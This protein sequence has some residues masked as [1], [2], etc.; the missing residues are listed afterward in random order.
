MSDLAD[1]LLARFVEDQEAAQEAAR[2]PA[3]PDADAVRV[4]WYR[5]D[6]GWVPSAS[7]EWAEG[8]VLFERLSPTRVLAECEAKRRIVAEAQRAWS[9]SQD[10]D[11]MPEGREWLLGQRQGLQAA[12]RLLALPYAAHPDYREEWQV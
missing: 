8:Q 6:T 5:H 12:L 3:P 1:F 4:V 9:R 7:G 10:D 11:P 2:R